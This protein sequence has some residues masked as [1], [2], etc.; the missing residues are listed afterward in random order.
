MKRRRPNLLDGPA[1]GAVFLP[2][3]ARVDACFGRIDLAAAHGLLL[4]SFSSAL[5]RRA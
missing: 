3:D 4:S 1:P 2:R 5:I